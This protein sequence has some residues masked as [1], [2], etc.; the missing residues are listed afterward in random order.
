MRWYSLSSNE[1]TWYSKNIKVKLDEA[2]LSYTSENYH[3]PQNRGSFKRKVSSIHP[4]LFFRGHASFP[5]ST[6]K[7]GFFSTGS[8]SS[9]EKKW[10][11]RKFSSSKT[12][13]KGAKYIKPI[14]SNEKKHRSKYWVK[15]KNSNIM[16]VMMESQNWHELFWTLKHAPKH[17]KAKQKPT[18]INKLLKPNQKKQP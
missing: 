11:L 12:Q 9:V 5:G 13:K 2:K 15:S 14:C 7:Y 8:W 6:F 18:K 1:F 16:M 17:L 4:I 3:V 10:I